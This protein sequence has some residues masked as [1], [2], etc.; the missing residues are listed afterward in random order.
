[1]ICIVVGVILLL[2]VTTTLVVNRPNEREYQVPSQ[3]RSYAS[4]VALQADNIMFTG[5]PPMVNP[6]LVISF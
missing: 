5:T 6:E 1:M 2:I 4:P 3:E